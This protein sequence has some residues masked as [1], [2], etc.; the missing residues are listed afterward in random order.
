MPRDGGGRAMATTRPETR[1][2]TVSVEVGEAAEGFVEALVSQGVECLFLNPGTDTFPVQEAIVKLESVGRPAPR[3][4]LCLFEI[5]ALAA[6]HGYYAAPGRPQAAL[7]AMLHNAQR[8]RAAVVIA[9]GRAPYT[10]DPALRGSRSSYIHWLQE[11]ADQHGIVRNYVKWDY[12]LRRSDQ[13]G[14]VVSRAFQ[15]A[16]SDPPGPVYMTLPRE[17]LMDAT[18]SVALHSPERFPPARIGA[19]DPAALRE[20]ARRLV[21][22]ERPLVL[23]SSNGRTEAG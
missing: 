14:E 4:V 17:A 16:A 23:T 8:G 5:V 6:A 11:Q 19:G 7:G 21:E 3:T 2:A 9:A 1:D 22:A 10:T 15:I 20:A 13:V 18:G 12:E